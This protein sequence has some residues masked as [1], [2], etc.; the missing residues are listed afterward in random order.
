MSRVIY[1]GRL[2]GEFEGF[3]DEALFKL[4]NGSYWLQAEYKYW[5]HY[6]YNPEVILSE[7]NGSVIL[8]VGGNSVAV[9]PT[10][11]LESR[12]Q[13]AFEGWKGHSVYTLTNGQTWAQSK[14]KYK[15]KYKYR[16]HVVV[17][18]ASSGYKMRVAGTAAFVRRV[19]L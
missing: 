7:Q 15:Y 14:Y 19:R 12:I 9:Q 5:Y 17:Y 10:E 1:D 16:P 18:R 11:A 8:S 4:L 3:D 13:G 6:A 2:D